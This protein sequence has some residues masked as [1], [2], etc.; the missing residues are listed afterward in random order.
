MRYLTILFFCATLTGC[1]TSPM[2]SKVVAE[3]YEEVA[4]ER[5]YM[6]TPIVTPKKI[7]FGGYNHKEV[8]IL[9]LMDQ[10]SSNQELNCG[11]RT[12]SMDGRCMMKKT[13]EVYYT[14]SSAYPEEIINGI[15]KLMK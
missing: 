15:D 1:F 13:K 11:D 12:R 14:K 2:C 9:C 4:N 8:A 5:M 10:E 7:T 3:F 6:M